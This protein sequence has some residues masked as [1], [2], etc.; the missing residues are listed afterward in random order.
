MKIPFLALLP[1]L[2]KDIR[3]KIKLAVRNG[4]YKTA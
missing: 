2:M 3:L 4:K 1:I